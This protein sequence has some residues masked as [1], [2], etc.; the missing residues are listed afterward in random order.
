MY[1][2]F[3][4]IIR[5]KDGLSELLP[6]ADIKS[7]MTARGGGVIIRHYSGGYSIAR[8]SLSD[9]VDVLQGEK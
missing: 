1:K 8:A 3:I 6:I 9:F 5:S 7:I 4:L 2:N